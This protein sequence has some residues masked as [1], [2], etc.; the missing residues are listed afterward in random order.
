MKRLALSF[1][2]VCVVSIALLAGPLNGTRVASFALPDTKGNFHDILDYRGK[3]VLIDV[4]Q[5][6]C[7][8]CQVLTGTLER[9]R[10]KYVGK[11][12]V[13]SIVIPPDNMNTVNAFAT[14]FKVTSPILF[15][16]GQASAALLRITPKN[17]SL[18][19]PH[20]VVVDKKGMVAEHWSYSDSLKEIF[21]GNGL[22]PLI[23]RLL[24]AR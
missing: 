3:V 17:P 2:M 5:T 10:T 6:A 8:H 7:P 21:A 12:A 23:D 16:S 19:V 9:V 15:D 20:L 14:R 24:A 1:A 13:L 11:V 4:M 18:D 22:V